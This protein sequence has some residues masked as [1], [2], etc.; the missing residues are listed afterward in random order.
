MTWDGWNVIFGRTLLFWGSRVPS[1]QNGALKFPHLL[2]REH[3]SQE[4]SLR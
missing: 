4:L 3:V 2:Q 1:T